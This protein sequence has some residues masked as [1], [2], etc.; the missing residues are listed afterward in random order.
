MIDKKIAA[1]LVVAVLVLSTVGV[2][3][4]LTRTPE[5]PDE[6]EYDF[7]IPESA[8]SYPIGKY[9][10][11]G[12]PHVEPERLINDGTYNG[13]PL[14]GFGS[15]SIGRSHRGEFSRWHLDVGNH[16]YDPNVDANQFSVF[17]DTG[18]TT[19]AWVMNSKSPGPMGWD[20]LPFNPGTYHALYPRAWYEYE[21]D[22]MP[23]QMVQEQ[24][25]PIIPNNY[26]E[27][28]YP[29]GVFEWDIYNPTDS[30]ISASVMFS[31]QNT[32]FGGEDPLLHNQ[33]EET[34]DFV[35]LTLTRDADF[36]GKEY[37]GEFAISAPKNESYEITYVS[38]FEV[39]NADPLWQDFSDDGKLTNTQIDRNAGETNIA[40]A[41]AVSFT[42][43][44]G[45]AIQVPFSLAWDMPVVS[46]GTLETKFKDVHAFDGGR[47]D[48]Y[49]YYT[50]FY[51]QSGRDAQSISIDALG[52]YS[53]WREQIIDWQQPIL[54]DPDRPDWYKAALFNELYYLVDGGSFWSDALVE[55]QDIEFEHP[56]TTRDMGY[57][58]YLETYD[59]RM[60]NTF[61][62]HF[63][64]PV[65]TMLWPKLQKTL[66]Q[67]FIETV[68][69]NDTSIRGLYYVGGPTTQ[70]TKPYGAVPHD[71]GDPRLGNPWVVPNAY[72]YQDSN[73]WLDLNA[74]LVMQIY[75]DYIL[76]GDDEQVMDDV[77]WEA[78]Y[79]SLE[80]LSQF[81]TDNNG[82]PNHGGWPDQTYDTLPMTNESAYT[83]SLMISALEA[84][85][86]IAQL[87]GDSA[88]VTYYD[89][90]ITL[91][92]QTR[93]SLLWNGEYYKFDHNGPID[94]AIMS[95]QLAGQWYAYQSELPAIAPEANIQS[96]LKKV[97]D[98]NVMQFGEGVMGA[99][100]VMNP[101]GTVP[102]LYEQSKEV[103]TGTTYGLAATMYFAGLIEEAFNT[104]YGVYHVTYDRG[105]WFR[106]PEAWVEN[107]DFRA[108]MYMRPLAI[109]GL[110]YAI[111]TS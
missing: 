92:K 46:F 83:S 98:F 82:L 63:Y 18:S 4:F 85:K 30:E 43:A 11:A 33:V 7:G 23:L 81:D 50:N 55:G 26:Q 45:E 73:R 28:S 62:V 37:D 9:Y 91:A 35:T 49:K 54:D 17:V 106:T 68:F 44:P 70:E 16:I 29:V 36:S 78:I 38:T 14:G 27:T 88:N 25:S 40:G 53:D 24:F 109:W 108:S 76:T 10:Q 22:G 8:W 60:Y 64:V 84:T 61:D 52:N 74:K 103:W 94:N 31:W 39:N 67:D 32:L 13:A 47:T 107:G 3:M 77:T 5:P 101:D 65:L 111:S 79:V 41:L 104:A 6:F 71:V 93:E 89:D 99:V 69:W 97:Y 100:N 57:F 42:I 105:Y 96:A 75:R 86:A 95:D 59:Y 20:Q 56:L 19:D 66:V 15:G 34:D 110:E 21:F 87:R 48:W 58:G 102:E 72:Q 51:G 12:K 80:Y 2:Y 1:V 90:W